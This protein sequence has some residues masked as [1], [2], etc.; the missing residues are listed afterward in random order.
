MTVIN[1]NALGMFGKI[2]EIFAKFQ[3]NIFQQARL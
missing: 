3:L 2:T 1:K